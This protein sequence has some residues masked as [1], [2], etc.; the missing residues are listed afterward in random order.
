[1]SPQATPRGATTNPKNPSSSYQ[2]EPKPFTFQQRQQQRTHESAN[3]NTSKQQ[4][5]QQQ[6]SSEPKYKSAES[7]D[8]GLPFDMST[9]MLRSLLRQ[10]GVCTDISTPSY[11]SR[12]SPMFCLRNE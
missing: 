9:D 4:Q 2:E 8:P 3:G 11:I 6:K 12:L 5:Q 7:D 10:F 1:M